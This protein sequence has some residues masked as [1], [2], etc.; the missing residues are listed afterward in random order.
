MRD[1][2]VA[3]RV[4]IAE[5]LGRYGRLIDARDWAALAGVFTEDAEFEITP[6]DRGP[7][8]GLA[9]IRDH[10]ANAARHPAAHHVTNVHVERLDDD[11]AHVACMLVAVQADGSVASGRYEDE[12]VRTAAGLR[13]RRRTFSWVLPPRP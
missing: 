7:L 13:V 11:C 9:E 4:E 1:I 6:L 8:R 10:M 2:T 3:E 12:I 5:M